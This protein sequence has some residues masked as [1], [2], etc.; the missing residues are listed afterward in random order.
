MKTKLI[1]SGVLFVTGVLLECVAGRVLS[2]SELAEVLTSIAKGVA[3][4]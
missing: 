3:K 4:K 1:I 2:N